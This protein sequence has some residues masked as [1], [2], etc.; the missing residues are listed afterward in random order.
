[1]KDFFFQERVMKFVNYFLSRK[2]VQSL[3]NAFALLSVLKTL[4]DNEVKIPF[5][6][7]NSDNK[8]GI[9]VQ[10]CIAANLP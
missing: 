1:M 8:K 10:C 2:H 3:Q 5:C 6:F 9:S 7:K 4:A